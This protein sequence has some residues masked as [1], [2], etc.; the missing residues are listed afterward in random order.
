MDTAKRA[1]NE[2]AQ[3]VGWAVRN[4]KKAAG[5]ILAVGG[6]LVTAGYELGWVP[7]GWVYTASKLL[8]LVAGAE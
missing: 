7:P 3:K 2:A 4:P 8:G 1:V 5:I 6:A